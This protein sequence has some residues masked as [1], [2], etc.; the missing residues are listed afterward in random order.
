MACSLLH[1]K[2]YRVVFYALRL[3]AGVP[4]RASDF[5]DSLVSRYLAKLAA[6]NVRYGHA[7]RLSTEC[8]FDF[9]DSASAVTR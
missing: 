8:A 4:K 1:V 2:R 7:L 3:F 6:I 5:V 9:Y